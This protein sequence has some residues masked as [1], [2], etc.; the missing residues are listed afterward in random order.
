MKTKKTRNHLSILALCA[1]L[2]AF[3][4]IFGKYLAL[5]LGESIRISFENLP[6]LLAGLFMGPA[7]GAAVG[8]VA[9]LVGCLMVGYAI[10]PV[11]SLGAACIG[12]VSGMIGRMTKPS[13]FSV[14]F[15]TVLSHLIGSIL[16]KTVGLWIY[17]QV[18]VWVTLGWRSLTYLI[19]LIPETALLILLQKNRGFSAQLQRFCGK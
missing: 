9:D 10:N 8:V 3:S 6:I 16:I 18:P 11:I 14:L 2:S 7:A 19:I 1:V 12:L 13:P 17:Y 5:N 4:I 15:A